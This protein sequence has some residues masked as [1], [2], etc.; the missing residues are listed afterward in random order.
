MRE[1]ELFSHLSSM[2][3]K[4]IKTIAGDKI[5]FEQ[6]EVIAERVKFDF[7]HSFGGQVIYIP[8]VR[9]THAQRIYQ[10]I[11]REFDGK[12]QNQLA[13]KYGY[14]AQWIYR[15]LKLYQQGENLVF[16]F[17]DDENE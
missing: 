1:S 6:M 15:I 4:N 8:S 16:D 3:L 5:P 10:K 11:F 13:R 2:V 7:A 9:S 14:S 17:G 12:N